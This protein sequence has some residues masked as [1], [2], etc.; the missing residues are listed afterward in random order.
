M[1]ARGIVGRGEAGRR[2]S[3]TET[4]FSAAGEAQAAERDWPGRLRC[5]CEEEP[6]G[7]ARRP[8]GQRAGG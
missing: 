5:R 1:P 6:R 3:N 2:G 7:C 8:R 4:P